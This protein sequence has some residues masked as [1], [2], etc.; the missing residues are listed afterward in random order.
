M[1]YENIRFEY[2]DKCLHCGND[3]CNN[4]EL[5]NIKDL[6]NGL[7]GEFR[8]YKCHLCELIYQNP[9]VVEEDIVH[10]YSKD[11]GYYKPQIVNKGPVKKFVRNL[12]I[13]YSK[14][15]KR[16][17]LI[18]DFVKNGKLLEIGCSHGERLEELKD[19]GWNDHMGIEMDNGAFRYAINKRK[20][21]VLNLRINEFDMKP[22]YYDVVIMS[23]VLEHLYNPFQVLDN[24][25]KTLKPNGQLLFSIP[26]YNGIEYKIFGKYSYGLQLPT[27][28]CFP[29]KRILNFFLIKNG[30]KDI[31]FY[32]HSFERDICASATFKYEET[33]K[34]IYKFIGKNKIIKKL[35]IK[36]L[37]M[38]LALLGMTG[39]ISIYA[40]KV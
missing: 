20:L 35:L 28:I 8:L 22:R 18:P 15:Y 30:F 37:V 1:D 39:R 33:G 16:L 25:S 12:L 40:K 21:N 14:R 24:I 23:M 13:R 32:H 17:R 9:R 2:I 7:P 36:P 19:M 27:H 5:D 3:S 31:K 4:I 10:Y 38:I 26:Y 6:I 34:W 29:T 11:M